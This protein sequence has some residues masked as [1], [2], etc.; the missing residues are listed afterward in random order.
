MTYI[1]NQMSNNKYIHPTLNKGESSPPTPLLPSRNALKGLPCSPPSDSEVEI[2]YDIGFLKATKSFPTSTTWVAVF[3][4]CGIAIEDLSKLRFLGAG[5]SR[6]DTPALY[7][8]LASCKSHRISIDYGASSPPPSS[9]P[10]DAAHST[11]LVLGGLVGGAPKRPREEESLCVGDIV[12]FMRDYKIKKDGKSAS[13]LAGSKGKITKL[14]NEKGYSVE[15]VEGAYRVPQDALESAV[16]ECPL[17]SSAI[18]PC[19]PHRLRFPHRRRAGRR[20]TANLLATTAPSTTTCARSSRNASA[21]SS[22]SP[23][24]SSRSSATP[25]SRS[26]TSR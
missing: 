20:P 15:V 23:P 16:R 24:R 12:Y 2:T 11:S 4:K 19:P 6:I 13:I 21:T 26:R 22:P 14:P 10:R 17:V 8:T 1:N 18:G 25:C 9:P 7:E 5:G 3:A